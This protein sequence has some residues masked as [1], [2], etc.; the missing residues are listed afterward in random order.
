[1]ILDIDDKAEPFEAQDAKP[2]RLSS[3]QFREM[4]RAATEAK[5][6]S[7]A[8]LARIEKLDRYL[9]EHLRLSF[10]NRIM[11]Q[12]HKFV[13]AYMACGGEELD[14]VDYILCKKVLRKLEGQSPAFVRDAADG[15]CA[16]LDELFG[17]GRMRC[18]LEY[19]DRLK[20]MI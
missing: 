19:L 4:L 8:N 1:M 7:E 13:P 3:A 15:L 5:R 12:F 2:M 20:R 10:G 11:G 9:I 18:C 16:C 17:A 14:G 6:I